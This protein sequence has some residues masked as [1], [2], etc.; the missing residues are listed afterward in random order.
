MREL[1]FFLAVYGFTTA[2]T[3]LTIGTPY[4]AFMK[5]LGSWTAELAT[6]AACTGFWVALTISVFVFSPMGA[7]HESGLARVALHAVDSGAGSGVCW[8]LYVVLTKLGQHDC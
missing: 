5:K 6:C 3:L 4:R 8:I 7:P 1:V 2:L